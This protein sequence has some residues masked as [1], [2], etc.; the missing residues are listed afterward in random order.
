MRPTFTIAPATP[1]GSASASITYGTALD[2]SQLGTSLGGVAGSFTFTGAD[3]G[4]V[5]SVSG[6]PYTEAYL[7]TPTDTT[8]YTTAT[9]NATVS[10]TQATPSG[11]GSAS[12]RPL[13]PQTLKVEHRKLWQ[14]VFNVPICRFF[15]F[16]GTLKTRRHTSP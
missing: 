10:V 7:F 12:R 6:S 14:H 5:L 9:G 11:S 4:K 16:D 13:A 8:D 15:T 2:G 3:N 1:S